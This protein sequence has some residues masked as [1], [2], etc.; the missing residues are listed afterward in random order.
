MFVLSVEHDLLVAAI[1]IARRKTCIFISK[2]NVLN[3]IHIKWHL[4][5]RIFVYPHFDSQCSGQLFTSPRLILNIKIFTK[6]NMKYN[7]RIYVILDINYDHIFKHIL[8]K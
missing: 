6:V 8:R 7:Q 2:V 3:A 5:K 1:S 4:K